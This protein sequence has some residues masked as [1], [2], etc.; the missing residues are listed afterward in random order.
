MDLECLVNVAVSFATEAVFVKQ[1][2]VKLIIVATSVSALYSFLLF[3][4]TA[5]LICDRINQ[6]NFTCLVKNSESWPPN[7]KTGSRAC[8]LFSAGHKLITVPP[9]VA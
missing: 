9:T 6:H 2:F 8:N 7:V 1:Q 3:W 4:K 5:S